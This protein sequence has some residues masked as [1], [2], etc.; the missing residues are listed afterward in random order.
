MS[1]SVTTIQRH[2]CELPPVGAWIASR[3][4]SSITSGSTGALEVEAPAHRAR[5]GEDVVDGR[6]VEWAW[7]RLPGSASAGA[8]LRRIMAAPIVTDR[9]R[10]AARTM[11]WRGFTMRCARCGSGHLFHALLHDGARLPAVRAALRARA[12]LLGRRARDQHHRDRRAVRDR[13]RRAA[14]SRRSPT[15]RWSPLLA[16]LVPIA[17]LGPI[18][19]YPF[20]KTVWVA[21]DL[22]VPPAARPQRRSPLT[23]VVPRSAERQVERGGVVEPRHAVLHQGEPQGGDVGDG[24]A[25]QRADGRM[26]VAPARRRSRALRSHSCA[27]VRPPRV[28]EPGRQRD[29]RGTVG[30]EPA[31]TS[32]SRRRRG[33]RRPARAAGDGPTRSKTSRALVT[34]TWRERLRREHRHTARAAT[35]GAR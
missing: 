34:P 8:N 23:T 27:S 6:E 29:R 22:G 12:G 24:E 33:H 4:H 15:S 32:G 18:V 35:T 28:D 21:V 9:R 20:S 1:A 3:R 2:P 11:F 30:R 7:W 14:R 26:A 16:I 5:G 19:Y 10:R 25:E 13:V 31:S 17:V